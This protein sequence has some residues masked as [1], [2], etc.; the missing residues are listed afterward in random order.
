L[1]WGNPHHEVDSVW[2]LAP[3]DLAIALEVLGAVL[4]ARSAVAEHVN[5]VPVGLFAHCGDSP[6]HAFEVS[7]RRRTEHRSALLLCRDGTAELADSYA[8]HVIITRGQS[9]WVKSPPAAEQRALSNDMPLLSE[10]RTFVQ[11]LAGGPPP[12]SS[13]H[14][15]AAIVRVL[16]D[17]RRLAGLPS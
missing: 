1:G 13:V 16:A 12:K 10:L 8:D 17:L 4:P 7:S 2:V 3:H 5:D 14:E 9:G 15:G 6:W 11:H